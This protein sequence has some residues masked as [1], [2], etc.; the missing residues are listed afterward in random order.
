MADHDPATVELVAS[1]LHG[2]AAAV[3]WDRFA[4]RHPGAARAT[5]QTAR[6]V[7]DALTAAGKLAD[8]AHDARVR[9]PYERRIAA[10]D[11]LLACYR[12]GHRPSE[13]LHRR[14]ETTRAA[15]AREVT[16]ASG[17]AVDGG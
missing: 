16:G 11:E 4:V 6:A 8:A 10:L 12:T 17:E 13:A 5:R 2:G 7:L 1:T 9:A 14:L 15:I 3:P